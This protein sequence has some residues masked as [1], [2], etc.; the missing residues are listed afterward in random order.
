MVQTHFGTKVLFQ[1]ENNITNIH[2]T[3]FFHHQP[4]EGR[5]VKTV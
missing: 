2:Q 5:S 3:M 1:I 4:L